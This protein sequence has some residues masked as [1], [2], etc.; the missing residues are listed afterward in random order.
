MTETFKYETFKLS[1]F[2]NNWV[3]TYR[4]RIICGMCEPL[5]ETAI[6]FTILFYRYYEIYIIFPFFIILFEPWKKQTKTKVQ[7]YFF[8]NLGAFGEVSGTSF[9]WILQFQGLHLE[10]ALDTSR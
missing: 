10:G 5:T 2:N 6:L 1:V 8:F 7:T 3:R 9:S 4:N